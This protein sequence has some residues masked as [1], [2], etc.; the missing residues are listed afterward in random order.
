MT[1]QQ[2]EQAISFWTRKTEIEKQMDPDAL[3]SWIHTYLSSHK[4]LALATSAKKFIRCTPL[5]YTWHDDALWIFTEGGL[6]FR[7]L[8]ENRHVA[9]TIFDEN[10]S[11]G[12]LQSIQIEGQIQIPELFGDIYRKEAAFRHLPIHTLQNLSEPM[13]LLQLIPTEITCLNSH[14]KKEGF[15]SRQIWKSK[16]R[17]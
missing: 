14:F 15:Q 2:Y 6:K 12:E 9:A 8:R 1:D 7:G 11:F 17:D 10:P 16:E 13:W 5:E 4:I 3:Y